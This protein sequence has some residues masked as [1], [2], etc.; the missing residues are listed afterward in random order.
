MAGAA[1]LA[2]RTMVKPDRLPLGA[3]MTA[4]AVAIDL[5]MIGLH[6]G[7]E[8]IIVAIG[9]GT[10][11]SLEHATFV[12]ALAILIHM[13]SGQRETSRKMVELLRGNHWGR[14]RSNGI[15]GER[16]RQRDQ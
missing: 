8:H 7:G 14:G 6:P 1:A 10:R 12:A 16:N 4:R 3:G 15:A 13:G 11:R 2:G 9:A 5:N